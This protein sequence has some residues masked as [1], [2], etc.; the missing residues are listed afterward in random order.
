MPPAMAAFV[1][2]SPAIAYCLLRDLDLY[3]TPRCDSLTTQAAAGQALTLLDPM[4]SEG[5]WRVR[6]L[7]DDY[8]GWL[9]PRD[10]DALW[11]CDRP[12]AGSDLERSEIVMRLPRVLAFVE[13]ALV[14]PNRYRWGG[15]LAPN[16]DCSGLMQAAF[17]SVGIQ[18]PR[19]AWQQQAFC[20]PLDC[21]LTDWSALD[22]GDLVFFGTVERITHVGLYRGDGFYLH[23][24]GQS[25]G[26]DGIGLDR[27]EA[28]F[29][30]VSAGYAAE[31]R[32]AGRVM[33]SYRPGIDGPIGD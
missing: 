33:R 16:Y 11:A 31:F 14:T 9:A 7:E 29:H 13:K 19:D 23:S 4:P 25:R 21:S 12:R 24:S 30:P 32:G 5:P 1:P 2:L 20:D 26:R 22:P 8:P 27:L 15:R 10:A 18:L 6:L 28:G 3:S 17:A